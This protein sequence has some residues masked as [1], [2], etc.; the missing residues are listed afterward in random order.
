MRARGFAWA[1]LLLLVLPGAGQAA[2]GAPFQ[3]DLRLHAAPWLDGVLD[4]RAMDAILD[5]TPGVQAGEAIALNATHAHGWLVESTWQEYGPS[6]RLVDTRLAREPQNATLDFGPL[7]L[8]DVRC[9]GACVVALFPAEGGAL[10]FRGSPGKASVVTSRDATHASAQRQDANGSASF[11]RALPPGAVVLAA[12]ADAIDATALPGSFSLEGAAGL[13]LANAAATLIEADGRATTLDARD[14]VTGEVSPLGVP[15]ERTVH[16]RF[17]VLWLAAP[18]LSTPPASRVVGHLDAPSVD[19]R[20]VLAAPDA[21]GTVSVGGKTFTLDHDALRLDGSLHAEALAL[22]TPGL[23]LLGGAPPSV[24]MGGETQS[25][26]INGVAVGAPGPGPATATLVGFGLGALLL[27]LLV[28]LLRFPLSPLYSRIAPSRVLQHPNRRRILDLVAASPGATPTQIARSLDLARVVVQHHLD[29]LETH[30]HV[31]R[32]RVGRS[33][34]YF[35]SALAPRG[36]ELV[37]WSELHEPARRRLAEA[38]LARGSATQSDLVA[39]TGLPQRLLSYH[40]GRMLEAGLVE[41]QGAWRRRYR[42]APPL[43]R[44]LAAAP[45]TARPETA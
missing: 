11:D 18:V 44:L 20:G 38:L 15:V 36:P 17:A 21:S 35:A 31:E 4:A 5:L 3:A 28:A 27:G 40:L 37:A 13:L 14:V 42:P 7:V 23:P 33:P 25:V 41:A 45:E 19:V 9:E 1:A 34:R 10:V 26:W 32:R 39:S 12:R 29:L 16:S 8:R 24:S 43:Q 22:G 2:A 30:H 6:Q